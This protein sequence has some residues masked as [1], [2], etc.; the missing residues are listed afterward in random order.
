MGNE[1]NLWAYCVPWFIV[2]VVVVVIVVDKF[3]CS[4]VQSASTLFRLSFLLALVWLAFWV[5]ILAPSIFVL[6][7]SCF[8]VPPLSDNRCCVLAIH[9]PFNGTTPPVGFSLFGAALRQSLWGRVSIGG[10]STWWA[11]DEPS[12]SDF[13]SISRTT[14]RTTKL[15][16]VSPLRSVQMRLTQPTPSN[17]TKLSVPDKILPDSRHGFMAEWIR[18][19]QLWTNSG[20]RS[21]NNW[22]SDI[23][24]VVVFRKIKRCV[25]FTSFV[26]VPI[27]WSDWR[28]NR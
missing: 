28:L 27:G 20:N 25:S 18:L 17:V 26:K 1:A 6:V 15:Q 4:F 5:I 21:W 19:R 24:K 3:A 2:V 11:T 9:S 7:D 12:E 16:A 10:N 13:V 23:C 14:T 22:S 8:F